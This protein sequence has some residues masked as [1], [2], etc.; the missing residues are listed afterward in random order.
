[1]ARPIVLETPLRDP[2]QESVEHLH[3]A[4]E[5]HAEALLELME[6]LEGLHQR[7][8][9]TV[10]RGLLAPGDKLMESA[11]DA[12]DSPQVIRG[13][14]NLIS[15]AKTLGSIDPEIVQSIVL[16]LAETAREPESA[17]QAPGTLSLVAQLRSK[18]AR[19]GLGFATR[20]MTSLGRQLRTRQEEPRQAAPN[21]TRRKAA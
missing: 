12:L 20:F 1:M 6:V 7:G 5:H 10:S 11:V 8:V 16:A 14:R 9:L 17:E 18:E 19:R 3:Q 4:P 15:L 21:A 2:H 13:F